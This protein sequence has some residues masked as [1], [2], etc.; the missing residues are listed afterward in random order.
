MPELKFLFKPVLKLD[1][2][3]QAVQAF[4]KALHSTKIVFC[5]KLDFFIQSLKS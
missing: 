1:L 4:F 5:S 3:V 2:E